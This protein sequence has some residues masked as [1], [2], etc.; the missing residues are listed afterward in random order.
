MC[1]KGPGLG[2]LSAEEPGPWVNASSWAANPNQGGGEQRESK[3][4]PSSCPC[5]DRWHVKTNNV[6]CLVLCLVG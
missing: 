5:C 2:F 6:S 3:R 1:S 4:V